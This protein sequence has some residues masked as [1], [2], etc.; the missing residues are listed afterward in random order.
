VGAFGLGTITIANRV[1]LTLGAR[2]DREKKTADLRTYYSPAIA[3]DVRVD[4]D[5]TFSDV[6]PQA[7]VAWRVSPGRLLYASVG[8][9]FKA[10]GF[11]P[12]SPSGNESYG[13]ERAWNAEAGLKTTWADGR[14]SLN[15]AAFR[16]SWDDMQL[17]VP[18]P[19][20][21]AQFYIA[22]VG[23]AT[24]TGVELEAHARPHRSVDIFGIYGL[25]HG[26]FGDGS[27][28]S[29]VD[30]SGNELPNA[31]GYTASA[32]V[33]LSRAMRGAVTCYGRAEVVFYGAYHYDDQNTQGQEA[34]S[35][36]NARA[37]IQVG[38]F[39]LEGWIRNAFDT[40]YIPVA[41]AYPGFAPSG[42]MGESGRPRTFGVSLSVGF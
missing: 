30:V 37:G 42:F 39:G 7:A 33:Q 10:G 4:A 35:L 28:S 34:Y 13:E 8:R 26:R 25:T 19:Y 29:G 6:S 36:A 27:R 15:A 12:A 23:R 18:N 5:R 9:G 22:N 11:N 20:V 24:S 40:K 38:K 1:D 31:P 21:P 2:V 14:V 3:P 32:G 16:L 41:F 17:N